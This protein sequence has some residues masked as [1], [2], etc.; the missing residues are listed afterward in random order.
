MRGQLTIIAAPS[1]VSHQSRIDVH[2]SPS[3][4]VPSSTYTSAITTIDKSIDPVKATYEAI[5]VPILTEGSVLVPI[6]V[7]FLNHLSMSRA[8][9]SPASTRKVQDETNIFYK[10]K[11]QKINNVG[12][13][14]E[15]IYRREAEVTIEGIE[16]KNL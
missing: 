10:T 12:K 7:H 15:T 9:A 13:P 8:L 2:H 4:I 5:L 16:L 6:P 3:Y 14:L 1:A 11:H